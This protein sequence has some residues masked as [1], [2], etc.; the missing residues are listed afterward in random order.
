MAP[1]SARGPA[2]SSGRSRRSAAARSRWR[3]T[4][5]PSASSECRASRPSTGTSRSATSHADR[6]PTGD[7]LRRMTVA[8]LA[9]P[10]WVE[11][12]YDDRE[13]VR[14]LV[15]DHSPYPL[16]MSSAGYGEM[17]GEFCAPWIRSHWAL[18]G[19]AVDD[20]A[21]ALLHHDP[22]VDAA[23]RML[24]AD[25]VRPATLLVN[26]MGPQVA[27]ARHVD[28]PTFRGLK[29]SEVPVWLLVVMGSSGLFE[30][31]RVHVAGGLTWFYDRDD[32]AYEYWPRGVD[33]PA[34][35]ARGPCGNA[36]LVADNDLMPHRVGAI[37]DSDDFASRVKVT[38]DAVITAIDD[39]AWTIAGTGTEPQRV[40]DADLR[41]SILWKA[42]TFVDA[43][44]ARRFDEHEDDLAV[45]TIVRV[46]RDDLRARGIEVAVPADPFTDPAWS[47]ALAGTYIAAL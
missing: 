43:A 15:R 39:G 47:R 29:R 25:V 11:P 4:S 7:R 21:H 5:S 26:L 40:E 2:S 18:D 33:A 37:G 6:P 44:D 31:W 38:N 27:G 32:G 36:A 28:T 42:L 22:F 35:L 16:M 13:A 9:T 1:W 19:E 24:D 41:V 14:A 34:E 3:A 23:K 10:V 30:E 17:A 20:A 12:A 46:L 8:E 45:E